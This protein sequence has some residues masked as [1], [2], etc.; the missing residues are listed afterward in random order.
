M[1]SGFFSL[2]SRER[3]EDVLESIHGYTQLALQL[4]DGDGQVLMGFG[5]ANGY[6]ALLRRH[7]FTGNECSAVH[8]QAGHHAQALGEAYVFTCHANLNHIAF[9]MLQGGKLLALV[10]I[11]PFLMDRPDSTLV[12]SVAEK[13]GLSAALS[14]VMY[15]ELSALPVLEPARVEYLSRLVGHLLS[16]LLP[17]ERAVQLANRERLY[18]QAKIN[19]TI[20]MYKGLEQSPGE[21]F[22]YEKET[23]LLHKVRTGN[24]DEAKAVLNELLGYVFFS[25][26]ANLETMRTRAIGLTALLSRVAMEGGAQPGSVESVNS[27]F[28]QRVMR[29]DTLED[30]CFLLQEVVEGFM[31]AMFD[32]LDKGNLYIRRALSCMARDYGSPI[33]LESVAGEVGLSPSYFS[34]LFHKTVGTGFR[35]HLNRIRI[36]ESRRLLLST[37]YSLTD[38]AVAVGFADQSYF[39]KIFR[40][41]VGITPGRFRSGSTDGEAK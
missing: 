26:G 37:D 7:V 30:L 29:A 21:S 35:E 34:T 19:E 31:S 22:L 23:D 40:Q 39:C 5:K 11:G 32:P 28:L 13:H 36:E 1:D 17:A 25:E 14:L 15:D 3:M 10:I 20:Q 16:P 9:P 2:V 24:M 12:S 41:I 27:G 38:I 8:R 18:Q 6:C 33:T 4:M